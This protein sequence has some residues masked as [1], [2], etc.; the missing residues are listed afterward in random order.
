MVSDDIDSLPLLSGLPTH[1]A[2]AEA[3]PSRPSS[4]AHSRAPSRALTRGISRPCSFEEVNGRSDDIER[5]ALSGRSSKSSRKE[6]E[7]GHVSESSFSEIGLELITDSVFKVPDDEL[8]DHD[9]TRVPL[10]TNGHAL[11]GD[12]LDELVQ[13]EGPVIGV[14]GTMMDGIANVSIPLKLRTVLRKIDGKLHY[15]CWDSR[16]CELIEHGCFELI[17]LPSLPYA[18]SQAGFVMG[19]TLLIVLA[20]VTDW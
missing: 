1:R 12:E 9:T 11:R 8:D 20:G 14:R 10:L 7:D 18:I 4:R 13:A 3:G 2:S 16:V 17:P 15:R 5:Q 19:V 6:E